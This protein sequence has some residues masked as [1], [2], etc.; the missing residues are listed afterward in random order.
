MKNVLNCLTAFVFVFLAASV[1]LNAQFTVVRPNPNTDGFSQENWR[2]CNHLPG[3]GYRMVDNSVGGESRTAIWRDNT[4][5]LTEGFQV[6]FSVRFTD[7]TG[8]AGADGLTFALQNEDANFVGGGGGFLGYGID[9][10][11]TP[12][13]LGV[14]FDVFENNNDNRFDDST[15]ND[16]TALYFNSDLSTSITPVTPLGNGDIEDGDWHQVSVV[17]DA[18]NLDFDVFFDNTHVV[19]YTGDIVALVFNGDPIVNWGFTAGK[20]TQSS[21]IDVCITFINID[22]RPCCDD[23]VCDVETDLTACAEEGDYGF[24][25]LKC[26]ARFEWR[27]PFGSTAMECAAEGQS[28]VV[29]MSEGH[30]EVEVT[31]PDGCTEILEF[32]VTGD[33]CDMQG[34]STPVNPRCDSG[35]TGNVLRWNPVPG[36]VEYRVQI[37]SGPNLRCDC[38]GP[39]IGQAYNTT[40]TFIE[41]PQ[42]FHECFLWTVEAIC[43]DGTTS[44]PTAEQCYN[45]RCFSQDFG[46][47][48]PTI[49]HA[50]HSHNRSSL[51][52]NPSSGVVNVELELEKSGEVKLEVID[53]AGRVLQTLPSEQLTEGTHQKV[54]RLD[55]ITDDGVYFIRVHYGDGNIAT[56]K[57]IIQ[58]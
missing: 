53:L 32:D 7:A 9:D 8:N 13:T 11:N 36:A 16:H 25:S 29:N 12:A 34:C 10:A 42:V 20:W 14:E 1:S 15:P 45:G 5:D 23:N 40:F 38:S 3:F 19:D 50:T 46:G 18:C 52:P 33:C 51:Y 56:H 22:N 44:P 2:T 37:T 35:I 58:Q 21:D 28:V 27:F 24:V 43:E 47:D 39:N 4:I 57:L 6:D 55:N 31:Y 49:N 17:W 48:V 54:L 41:V 26:D 30:Y